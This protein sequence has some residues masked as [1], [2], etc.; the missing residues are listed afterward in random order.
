[1][2]NIYDFEEKCGH[3]PVTVRECSRKLIFQGG[4]LGK[5]A[6]FWR[7][8]VWLLNVHE[9]KTSHGPTRNFSLLH[10]LN[11]NYFLH[12]GQNCKIALITDSN[13][14][15]IACTNTIVPASC[16]A[17]FQRCLKHDMLIVHLCHSASLIIEAKLPGIYWARQMS[18]WNKHVHRVD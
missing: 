12:L 17:S 9:Y 16:S 14:L 6:Y 15:F 18:P 11:K 5:N 4:A 2:E 8:K 13:P 1:M 10:L 3:H 7:I